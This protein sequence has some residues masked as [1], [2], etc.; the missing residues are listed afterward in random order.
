M[1]NIYVNCDYTFFG[2]AAL[3]IISPIRLKLAVYEPFAVFHA[4]SSCFHLKS[5]QIVNNNELI[6]A[7][8]RRKLLDACDIYCAVSGLLW[9]RARVRSWW[10]CR[11]REEAHS[12]FSC[13]SHN[14]LVL[15]VFK[16]IIQGF[17]QFSRVFYHSTE[18]FYYSSR[19]LN[20]NATRR[21]SSMHFT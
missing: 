16:V 11:A 14:V 2:C 6:W 20:Q 5:K 15:S 3:C 9:Y 1:R 21:V 7:K 17:V 8:Y 19:C 12:S 18:C 13:L 4:F 10:I